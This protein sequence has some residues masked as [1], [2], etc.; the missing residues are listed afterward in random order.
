MEIARYSR[1]EPCPRLSHL[2]SRNSG[3]NADLLA[4]IAHIIEGVRAGGDEALI[5]YTERF[6]KVTLKAE[7]IRVD[8][9]F[10][11]HTALK[12]DKS[13]VA[14]FRTAIT[15]VR[16]FH[17]RQR[18]QGWMMES[19]AGSQIG[20]RVLPVSSAGLYVPG[21]TAAYPSSVIMNAV[22]AQVAGVERIAVVTP[23]DTLEKV[24]IVAAVLSELGITEVYRVGGAQAIAAFAYGTET[25][26]RVDKIVGPGNIYVALAKKLVFGSVGIDSVAGPTE[27]V[28]LAD[29]S[30]NVKFV[31]ADM[32]AQAEH[33]ESASAICITTSEELARGVSR[34]VAAQVDELERREIAA[35]S[36]DEFGSI[37]LVDSLEAGCELV[38]E[39]APEHLELMTKENDRV[40]GMIKSAGAIFFGD[41]SSEPVGDYL[42]GPNHVLPTLGTARFSSPLGV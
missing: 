21:G 3:V 31:A 28:V 9:D 39:I 24:P 34:Q 25:I 30:A 27:V 8:P 4:R 41:W 36:I 11:S 38:N 19:E 12:A 32:L 26:A 14:A 5:H 22:P 1:G 35:K 37:F 33:D 15:N 18:E 23:P 42:A 6:D 29:E 2:R 40:A 10:I 20:V 16:L 17:E 13:V 7:E